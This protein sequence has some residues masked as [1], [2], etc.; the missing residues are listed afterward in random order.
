MIWVVMICALLIVLF[1]TYAMVCDFC[2][3]TLNIAEQFAK[4]RGKDK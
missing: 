1:L 4:W 2:D 3:D